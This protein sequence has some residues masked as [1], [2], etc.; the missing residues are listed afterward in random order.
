MPDDKGYLRSVFARWVPAYSRALLCHLRHD[1]DIRKELEVRGGRSGLVSSRLQQNG[2]K[3][4]AGHGRERAR[5]ACPFPAS[6]WLRV[7]Q[8][9]AGP[10]ACVHGSWLRRHLGEICYQQH[11]HLH[12]LPAAGPARLQGVLQP[13]EIEEV[14]KAVHRPNYVLQACPGRHFPWPVQGDTFLGPCG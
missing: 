1:A 14:A 3:W 10:R 4:K 11:V 6:S 12:P 8:R 2:A 7:G 5:E 9:S 13:H